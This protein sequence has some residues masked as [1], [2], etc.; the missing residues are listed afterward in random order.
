MGQ[1]TLDKEGAMK[2]SKPHHFERTLAGACLVLAPLLLLASSAVSPAIKSDEGAQLAVIAQHPD[3]FYLFSLLGL[4]SAVLLV[5]ALLGLMQM[6][7]ERAPGWGY[8]GVG[9][10]MLGNLLSVGDWM[11]NF[12]QWQMAVPNAD[13]AE[14][15]AL[16]TR[17]DETA[18]S[19]L[20]LQISGFAFLVGT[21]AVAIGLHRARAVPAWSALGLVVGIVVNL[22][23]FV[24]G[25]VPLLI[26]SS[27]V[28]LIAMGWI[29]R[30]VLADSKADWER[31]PQLRSARPAA[32]TP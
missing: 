11:G 24:V 9:L 26:V 3:R 27:A 13:R 4:V 15:T 2:L 25:S 8:V 6:L 22:A 29:G 16:L 30:I 23:G 12:V 18:G 28:L 17:L 32:G 31:S 5:P 1:L 19:A 7:R 21:A 20:P 14:M 10:M